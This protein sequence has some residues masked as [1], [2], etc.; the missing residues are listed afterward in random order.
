MSRNRK[1]D[2]R[3]RQSKN[4]R[5]GT[6]DRGYECGDPATDGGSRDVRKIRGS[7]TIGRQTV[8]VPVV[9]EVDRNLALLGLLGAGAIVL[10][11]SGSDS[12]SEPTKTAEPEGDAP[13][14]AEFADRQ[15]F[16]SACLAC[17]EHSGDMQAC[18]E[19][20]REVT[21]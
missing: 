21:G 16:M 11:R 8:K 17:S 14:P 2:L 6:G 3:G 20:W 10:S 5:G 7:A 18:S 1:N 19:L 13:D 12:E 15:A 9:G 4:L